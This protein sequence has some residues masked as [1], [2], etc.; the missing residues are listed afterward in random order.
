MSFQAFWKKLEEICSIGRIP[1]YLV[2][3]MS[4]S[5]FHSPGAFATLKETDILQLHSAIENEIHKLV[6]MPED[7]QTK[8]QVK[9]DMAALCQLETFTIPLGHKIIIRTI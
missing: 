2:H 8:L 7:N 9:K 3:S 6:D 5:G 1:F 4:V